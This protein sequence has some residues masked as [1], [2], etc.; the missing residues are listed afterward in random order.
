MGHFDCVE[1]G[2]CIWRTWWARG[3]GFLRVRGVGVCSIVEARCISSEQWS[4]RVPSPFDRLMPCHALPHLWS[5]GYAEI[6]GK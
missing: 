1:G 6:F 5:C 4:N 2:R 3:I